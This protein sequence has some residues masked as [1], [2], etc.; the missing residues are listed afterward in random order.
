MI[1]ILEVKEI[2]GNEKFPSIR[3][4]IEETAPKSKNKILN[5]MKNGNVVAVAAGRATDIISGEVIDEELFCYSDGKYSW[6]SDTIYYFEK[7]NIKL[8]SEFI[9]YA[10]NVK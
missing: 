2:Y 8:P 4:L 5:Y 1:S 10:L 7:Y 9:D 6:R 3:D